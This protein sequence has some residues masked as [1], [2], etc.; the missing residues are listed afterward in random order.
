VSIRYE[1]RAKSANIAMVILDHQILCYCL[2]RLT[3]QAPS[4]NARKS[5]ERAFLRPMP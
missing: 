3:V 4:E 5:E 2:Y 1:Y